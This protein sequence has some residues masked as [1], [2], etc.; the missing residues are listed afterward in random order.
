MNFNDLCTEV[1]TITN[2]PDLVNET[3]QAV[4]RATIKMH[5]LDFFAKD[6]RELP[7][8]IPLPSNTVQIDMAIALPGFR[9]IAYIKDT[10]VP[11]GGSALPTASKMYH[12]IDVSE[13]FDEYQLEKQ[14]IWYQGG[15]V[16]NIKSSTAISSLAIGYYALPTVL[17]AGV[18]FSWIAVDM[19]YAII[20]E[21]SANI[22]RLTGNAEMA[23]FYEQQV[24]QHAILLRQ[25]YLEGVAR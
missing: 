22:F 15:Q 11:A 1:Q 19:P 6:M 13:L 5:S 10:A 21:A 8:V 16:I 2:R 25:N 23:R 4:R 24:A 7:L 18:Y 9:A 20:D 17:P 3:Q 12:K 14:N